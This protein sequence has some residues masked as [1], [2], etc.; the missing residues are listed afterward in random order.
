[1]S[2]LSHPGNLAE[3]WKV[4]T[5]DGIFFPQGV[6]LMRSW[7]LPSQAQSDRVELQLAFWE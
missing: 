5:V 4:Q 3:R 2:D 1:M 7:Q 6:E